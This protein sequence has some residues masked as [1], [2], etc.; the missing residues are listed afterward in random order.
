MKNWSNLKLRTLSGALIVIL[1]APSLF[2]SFG[3]TYLTIVL[4]GLALLSFSE[5]LN[6]KKKE[7]GE[8]KGFK[9]RRVEDQKWPAWVWVVL[10]ASFLFML[11]FQVPE[12]VS[13][14]EKHL[15][16]WWIVHPVS[17]SVFALAIFTLPVFS[18]RFSPTSA[19]YVF[20]MMVTIV[21]AFRAMI[22]MI[23]T[24]GPWFK[25]SWEP[26]YYI[27][28]FVL[29]ITFMGDAFAYFCGRLFGK[30]KLAP[31][32]SPK[33]TWEG[34]IGSFFLTA[35]LA[36]ALHFIMLDGNVKWDWYVTGIIGAFL[37]AVGVLGDLAFSAIK[38][39]FNIKDFS[40]FIPG[41]GGIL[42]RVDSLIFTSLAFY[43]VCEFMW[44][45]ELVERIFK[46]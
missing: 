13:D 34:A 22:W 21:A 29:I 1:L 44:H 17:L 45:F 6:V 46:R 31:R 24:F 38:R 9:L 41:H 39:F 4:F 12:I 5:I 33:K 30:H 19:S 43:L 14:P 20:M 11:F 36:I 42:D 10:L 35:G 32:V 40:N 18:K 15:S 27:F 26:T 2:P 16:K 23:F 3:P 28:V 37:M 8:V 7:A 25:G